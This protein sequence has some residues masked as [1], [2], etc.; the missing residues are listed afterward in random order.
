MRGKYSFFFHVTRKNVTMVVIFAEFPFL[1]YN[2]WKKS[3]CAWQT[4]QFRKS[5]TARTVQNSAGRSFL[6]F[7]ETVDRFVLNPIV[8][9][10]PTLQEQIGDLSRE[11]PVAN[12]GSPQSEKRRGKSSCFTYETVHHL[13]YKKMWIRDLCKNAN[14]ISVFSTELPISFLKGFIQNLGQA[15]KKIRVSLSSIVQFLGWIG[16]TSQLH[17][18]KNTTNTSYFFMCSIYSVRGYFAGQRKPA[19]DTLSSGMLNF[20]CCWNISWI[21]IP[22][23]SVSVSNILAKLDMYSRKT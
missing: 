15:K 17:F 16:I 13:S 9:F 10:S 18:R 7:A 12:F 23:F 22:D 19:P 21:V 3:R 8:P 2:Q 5:K 4:M 20:L 1:K 14:R 6:L 11:A